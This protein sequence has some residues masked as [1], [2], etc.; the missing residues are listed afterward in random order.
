MATPD[1]ESAFLS[2]LESV[3]MKAPDP[4]AGPPLEIIET[5][6]KDHPPHTTTAPAPPATV[7]AANIWRHPDAH[8]IV[9]DLALLRRYGPAWLGWEAETLRAVIPT[10][11]ATPTVSELNIS[12][13][14]ACKAM[15]LVDTFWQQ[16]E[17]FL[18]CCR[19]LNGEFPDFRVMAVPTAAQCLVACDIA[20][21]I[22]QD[23]EWS[24]EMKEYLRTVYEHDGIYLHL[25][26]MDFVS[27]EVPALV[28]YG[29]LVSRWKEVR[30]SGHAPT[31]ETVLDEQL[32][33]LLAAS[34]YLEA[35]RTHLHHQLGLHV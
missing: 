26:P 9:L 6:D 2:A 3:G 21:R 33:R 8:P 35:S 15:H 28:D 17:I 13:L 16:W 31:G 18:H 7:T 23:V 22:R 34:G 1:Y 29:A 11:F 27:P 25:P 10:D 32:R 5:L 20:G 24:G 4:A 30:A 12:K 14:Q 19:P